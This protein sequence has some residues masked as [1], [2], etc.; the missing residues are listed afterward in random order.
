[1]AGFEIAAKIDALTATSIPSS[2]SS[3]GR[4]QLHRESIIDPDGNSIAS[5]TR[6]SL[7]NHEAF[8]NRLKNYVIGTNLLALHDR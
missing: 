4:G 5:P 1:M 6:T 2:C 3:C 8:E 7:D